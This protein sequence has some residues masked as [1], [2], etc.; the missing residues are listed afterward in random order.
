MEKPTT[1]Q[2]IRQKR[3][4]QKLTQQQLAT[5]VHVSPQ[6]VSNWEREYTPEIGHDDIINLAKALATSTDYLLGLTNNSSPIPEQT[7]K[8]PKDLEK[9]LKQ[10]EVY[11]R[12]LL[13]KE[14][15]KQY[16]LNTLEFIY[17]RTKQ[18]KK[19]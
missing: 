18:N 1:A 7:E 8:G 2:R 17:N 13:L 10:D 16:I 19:D 14:E 15:D 11:Y 3:Q 12:D 9:I 6:V 4:D 5:L